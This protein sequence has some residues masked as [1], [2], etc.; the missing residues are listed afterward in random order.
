MTLH[1]RTPT[2][3]PPAWT[4][5]AYCF[6]L[7]LFGLWVLGYVRVIDLD[8]FHEMALIRAALQLGSLPVEDIFAYTSTISPSVHHEWGMGA[9]LYFLTVF[10]DLGSH[11][12]VLL[13]LALLGVVVTACVATARLRGSGGVELALFAPLAIIL[14]W[15]GLSPVRAHMVTFA[16]LAI[17]LYLLELDRGGTRWWLLLW[18]VLFVIWLNVHGGFVVGAGM[19]GLYTLE[20]LVR[21]RQGRNWRAAVASTWH[22]GAATGA[23]L[24]LL[25]VNP[26]GVDYIPYLW[27]ALLLNRP[28]M[29]EWAPLW[30]PGRGAA[31]LLF[32]VS[33]VIL[34]YS[35]FRGRPYWRD[36]P[37]LLLVL[38]AALAALDSIRILPIY[39]VVWMSYVPAALATTP[40]A[41]MVRGW[42]RRHAKAI[43]P[44]AVVL[45]AV[46]LWNAGAANAFV[47]TLPTA[48]EGYRQHYPAGA[49]A[50]LEN[51]GFEGNLMTPFGVG[52]YVSWHLHP[53][54]KVGMDSRY[55]VAYPPALAEEAMRIYAGEGTWENFLDRFPTDA[56]LVPAD[57][58]LDG[59]L[60][61]AAQSADPRWVEVYRD[62]AYAIFAG[63]HI[64]SFLPRTDRRG[65]NIP[66]RFP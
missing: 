64:A 3:R 21:E 16:F 53:E 14:F 29:P 41:P 58:P 22:L 55:E 46:G 44:V 51:T 27:H 48:G 4:E 65:Q 56:V 9:V 66:G 10:L 63:D 12:L 60:V 2:D 28:M 32:A 42:W 43:A 34:L 13:R 47:L 25:L 62:D 61:E 38:V 52:A 8:I 30:A 36:E 45:A 20:R 23:T 11:G 50:Y 37:G 40:L 6:A 15:P 17:L 39:M 18:P 57:G 5:W 35:L 31:L 24:P 54:V 7:A 26:Y 1:V 33:V 49:V 19:L 59:S